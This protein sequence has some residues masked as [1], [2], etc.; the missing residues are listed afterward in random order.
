LSAGIKRLAL[1]LACLMALAFS[2]EGRAEAPASP[3]LLIQAIVDNAGTV[4]E[5]GAQD[6]ILDFV[7]GLAGLR[8]REYAAARIDLILTSDPRTVWSGTP[9][10][11]MRQGHAVLELV[12]INDRCADIARALRQ[13]EQNLK[14]ARAQD[15]VLLILSPLIAAPFPCDAGPDITLPQ[16]VPAGIE[17]GRLVRER[18]IRALKIY[19][20]HPSQEAPWTDHLIEQGLMDRARAGE[21]ELAFLG[22]QQSRRALERRL[23]LVPRAR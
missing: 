16:P 17:L 7:A 23:L 18:G 6:L 4:Q 15:A 22:I 19:G 13:A 11:L 5:K 1:A 12:R 2:R 3:P 20:V 8:G 10:D 9:A 14:A 21:L